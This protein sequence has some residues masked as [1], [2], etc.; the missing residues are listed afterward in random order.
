LE[1]LP[2]FYPKS[3][4]F[5]PQVSYLTWPVRKFCK[6][7]RRV[8]LTRAKPEAPGILAT[9]SPLTRAH[10]WDHSRILALSKP[11]GLSTEQLSSL[12]LANVPDSM[13]LLG[14]PLRAQSKPMGVIESAIWEP[15]NPT[16]GKGQSQHSDTSII[17]DTRHTPHPSLLASG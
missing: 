6:P 16:N 8:L 14:N 7:F 11:D 10:N 12:P 1:N 15:L 3:C 4:A 2:K 9:A 17:S 5:Q 13:R